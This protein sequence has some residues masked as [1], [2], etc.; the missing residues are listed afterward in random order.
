MSC[1]R[2]GTCNLN[3]IFH[4]ISCIQLRRSCGPNMELI[5]IDKRLSSTSKRWKCVMQC[6]CVHGYIESNGRCT[7]ITKNL[8]NLTNDSFFEM[9]KCINF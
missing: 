8:V 7:K 2:A 4:E 1:L 3:E 6:Q 9:N 5:I